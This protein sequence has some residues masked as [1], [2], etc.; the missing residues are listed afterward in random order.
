[1]HISHICNVYL[2]LG[3]GAEYVCPV[4]ILQDLFSVLCIYW[5]HHSRK[6][7]HLMVKH[8]SFHLLFLSYYFFLII[9]THIQNDD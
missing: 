6:V 7:S 5:E 2:L 9:D 1:M 3:K 4:S 8:F